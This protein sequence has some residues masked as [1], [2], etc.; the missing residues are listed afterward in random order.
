[1]QATEEKKVARKL[2]RLKLKPRTA[3]EG[4]GRTLRW[5]P[6]RTPQGKVAWELIAYHPWPNGRLNRPLSLTPAN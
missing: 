4:K 1:M 2:E 3:I 5:V 6:Y